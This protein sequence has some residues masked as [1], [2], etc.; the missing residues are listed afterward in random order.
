M[1][2]YIVKS[3][4]VLYDDKLPRAEVARAGRA[5]ARFKQSSEMFFAYRLGGVFPDAEARL[6]RFDDIHFL[7][8]INSI[9]TPALSNRLKKRFEV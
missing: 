7:F 2:R 1:L 5:E 6:Y 3:I 8:N 9:S 4:T